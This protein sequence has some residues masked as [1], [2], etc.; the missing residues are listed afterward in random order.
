MR[1]DERLREEAG[2]GTEVVVRIVEIP[3]VELELVVV[4]V[5]VDRLG[6]ATVAVR[7]LPLSAHATEA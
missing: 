6:E 5:E 1:V 7:K 4:D 3:P 2:G